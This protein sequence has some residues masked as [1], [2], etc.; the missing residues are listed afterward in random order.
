[1]IISSF[2][3]QLERELPHGIAMPNQQELAQKLHAVVSIITTT[4]KNET[5]IDYFP[6]L[7]YRL[8]PRNDSKNYFT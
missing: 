6:H 1:M 4:L 2:L 8:F 7:H 5:F 3:K